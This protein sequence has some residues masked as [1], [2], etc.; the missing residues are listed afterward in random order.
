MHIWIFI[1]GKSLLESWGTI[2]LPDGQLP[3]I[4]SD[5]LQI[6]MSTSHTIS[7]HTQDVSDE[8]DKDQG[9]LS[10]RNKSCNP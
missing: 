7:A 6:H 9:W 3:L 5:L 10:V 8:S 4:L 2:F 1:R